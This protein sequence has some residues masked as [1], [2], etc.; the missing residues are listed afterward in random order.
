MQKWM[1]GLAAMMILVAGMAG[2]AQQKAQPMASGYGW[3]VQDDETAAV[4]EAV[5]KMA[6][7]VADPKLVVLYNTVGYDSG[8]VLEAVNAK[9]ANSKVFGVTSC[10]AVVT[11][12]GVHVGAKGSLAMMGFA[13]DQLA[14]GVAGREIQDP[15]AASAPVAELLQ[16]AITDAG[17]TPQDKPAMILLG[18]TPG[19]EERA[20]EGIAAVF[21]KDAPVYGGSAADNDI[22]GKWF[23]F[24]KNQK[25]PSGVSVAL[26]YTPAKV[27]SA[28]ACGY[29]AT[30]QE[31]S[32]KVTSAEGRTLLAINDTP[33]AVV[34]NNW[35][36]GSIK[37]ELEKGGMILAK[38]SLA[39]LAR[40]VMVGAES[41]FIS[42]HPA[43]VDPKTKSLGLFAE[44]KPGEDV[45]LLKGEEETLL[46][47]SASVT[48]QALAA[49]QMQPAQVAGGL[50]I[51][52][53][54]TMLA[55]QKSIDR[56]VPQVN[57]A[58]AGAPFIGAFTF[59]EQGYMSGNGNFQGNLMNSMVLFGKE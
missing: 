2:C 41:V 15:A 8:K 27:A 54:G 1:A 47:R 38:S 36:N 32:G 40:K 24:A 26:V 5:A 30:G 57:E 3:S 20:I 25:I 45:Y 18:T 14:V 16:E 51:Y 23:A 22:S 31:Q 55:V 12:D 56:I 44:I 39:P 43:S 59:G 42:M 50:H 7:G 10:Y 19:F 35:T 46:R 21:G 53:A 48:K 37:D 11:K 28:F 49:S 58:L 34:Y 33:A 6:A 9:L 52:C 17:K 4:D 29:A 13:S